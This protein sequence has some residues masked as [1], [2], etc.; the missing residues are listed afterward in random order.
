M[1]SVEGCRLNMMGHGAVGPWY[2][3]SM[4]MAHGPFM[5]AYVRPTKHGLQLVRANP[6]AGYAAL[7]MT[8]IRRDS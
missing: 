3:C 4:G 1:L 2:C 6:L 8:Y 7:A 5:P